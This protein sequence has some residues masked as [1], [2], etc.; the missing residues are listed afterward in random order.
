MDY[1]TV[2][3][4]VQTPETPPQHNATYLQLVD[5]FTRALVW[6][7]FPFL[8]SKLAISSQYVPTSNLRGIL[9]CEKNVQFD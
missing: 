5:I 4:Q 9:T 3:E 6:K 7:Q 2:G 8:L 1:H